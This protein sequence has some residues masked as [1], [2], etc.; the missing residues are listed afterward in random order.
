M[1]PKEES[2]A[3]EIYV[4]MCRKGFGLDWQQAWQQ[5]V[6]EQGITW[7]AYRGMGAGACGPPGFADAGALHWASRV[8]MRDSV[9]PM[10]FT[11]PAIV[12][13]RQRAK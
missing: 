5:N 4:W 1:F 13:A 2:T 6:R 12:C 10:R 9:A 7:Y 11:K 3:E 8:V